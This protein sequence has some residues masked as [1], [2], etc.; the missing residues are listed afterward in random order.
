MLNRIGD[1]AAVWQPSRSH[2]SVI[3]TDALVEGRHFRRERMPLYDVGWRAMAANLSDLA[4][5]GARPVLATAALGLPAGTSFEEIAELY[6]GMLTIAAKH[7]C[8]L[9]GGDLTRSAELFVSIS[10][11]GEVRPSHA[12]GRAGARPGDVAAV[13]GALGAS[14][15]GLLLADTPGMLSESLAA[16]SLTAHARPEPR[17]AEGRWLGASINV[18]AM[19]DVSDGLSTDIYRMCA[20]SRCGATIADVPVAAG[21]QALAH[22]RGEDPQLF[23]LAGGEDFE[24]LVAVDARAFRYLAGRFHRRFGR[25]LLAVG[26]F[27]E[28]SGLRV[29]K[30]GTQE[31]LE[32]SGYDHFSNNPGEA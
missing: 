3:T 25:P 21:A 20:A 28:G 9:A 18:H 12:K 30:G 31:P 27:T 24:L 15:A 23:A 32:P 13:T 11:V 7:G 4:A 2:R 17:L 8:A 19:M 29:E 6:R 26:C 16:E 5:M 10:A 14:R 22:A 1:D